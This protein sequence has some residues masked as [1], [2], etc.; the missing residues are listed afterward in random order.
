MRDSLAYIVW[1]T[2]FDLGQL[3]DRTR[4]GSIG[5]DGVDIKLALTCIDGMID[6]QM[7]RALAHRL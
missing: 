1:S 6:R 2:P 4:P 3:V 5:G 7:L